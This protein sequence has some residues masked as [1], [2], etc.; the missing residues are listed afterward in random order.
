MRILPC[1]HGFSLG[2]FPKY[3]NMSVGDSKLTLN[4]SVRVNGV[5]A[6]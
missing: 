1:L 5:C 2:F 3:K 4:V 6:L